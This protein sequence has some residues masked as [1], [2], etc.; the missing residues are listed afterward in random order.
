M[1]GEP[2]AGPSRTPSRVSHRDS[3]LGSRRTT[4]APPPTLLS[5]LRDFLNQAVHLTGLSTSMVPTPSDY[6]LSEFSEGE[7]FIIPLLYQTLKAIGSTNERLDLLTATVENLELT[8]S[9]QPA[10]LPSYPPQD[11]APIA[12]LEASVCNLS[13]RFA[14]AAT[15]SPPPPPPPLP[16]PRCQPSPPPPPPAQ[17]L[18]PLA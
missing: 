3:P 16:Q 2:A 13:S 15:R 1:A 4:P 17:P 11:F 6:S 12:A 7:A 18:S 8:A 9:P 10:Q 5:L 14:A